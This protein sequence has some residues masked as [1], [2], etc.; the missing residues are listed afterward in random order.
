MSIA[1]LMSISP[2][3]DSIAG[4]P[5]PLPVCEEDVVLHPV[6]ENIRAKTTG[7]IMD[8]NVIDLIPLLP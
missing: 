8:I 7:N 6:V 2:L 1:A 3:I 5:V 4:A